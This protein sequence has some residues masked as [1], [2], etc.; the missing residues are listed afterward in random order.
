V[1][2]SVFTSQVGADGGKSVGYGRKQEVAR[3]QDESRRKR[4]SPG[5]QD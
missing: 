4:S 2:M 3:A 1:S 5:G